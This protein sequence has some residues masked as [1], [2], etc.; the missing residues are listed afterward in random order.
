M[1]T[2]PT[3][4]KIDF[5]SPT[6]HHTLMVR[7]TQMKAAR[8][9]WLIA[10]TL[11]L[12]IDG[13]GM[14]RMVQDLSRET[15]HYPNTAASAIVHSFMAIGVS[16]AVG[17]IY[18]VT[19]I[20]LMLVSFLA[21][22]VILFR[23]K[24]NDWLALHTGFTL[25]VISAFYSQLSRYALEPI[26]P[27]LPDVMFILS[28][29]TLVLMMLLFPDGRFVPRWSPLLVVVMAF[30]VLIT[31]PTMLGWLPPAPGRNV[32]VHVIFLLLSLSVPA[33][34]YRRT[35]NTIERLQTQWLLFPGTGVLGVYIVLAFGWESGWFD[36]PLLTI[37]YQ[38]ISLL[39][40]VIVP[41]TIT[42]AVLRY[43]L[44]NIQLAVNRS[45]VYGTASIGLGVLFFIGAILLQSAL[46]RIEPTISAAITALGVGIF[47]NPTRHRVQNVID[48]RIYGFRFNL[49]E[50][51]KGQRRITAENAGV[52]TGQTLGHFMLM[53][54][55]GKGGMGEVY[56]AYGENGEMVAV[57]VLPDQLAKEDEFRTRFQLEAD[58]LVQLRH[59]N[60]V[61]LVASGADRGKF[62]IAMEFV[63]GRDLISLLRENGKIPL[64]D[65]KP[66]IRDFAEAIDYAHQR[67]FIH[68]DIKPANII[69]RMGPDN[70]NYEAVLMDFGI[71]KI[72]NAASHFTGSGAVG[73]I[74]YMA[75]EQIMTAREVDHRADIYALGVVLYEML[76]GQRPFTGSPGQVL[77]AHIQQPPPDPREINPDIPRHVAK[78][79]LKALEKDVDQRFQSAGE[80]AAAICA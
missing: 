30:Y 20:A 73:T 36:A 37:V 3:E 61:G 48:R 39:I 76:T 2:Q 5:D 15:M 70:E 59:R 23:N 65:V 47:F 19:I 38:T 79:I 69:L 56:R 42:V 45:I 10:A 68:R 54:V 24:P 7:P 75:P 77:F 13:M 6:T 66:F 35:F 63:E 22:A 27:A 60:I 8:R 31:R 62:Y 80:L 18:T 28:N 67:G 49:D 46:G 14:G 1:T 53:D 55:V 32:I 43:R 41:V 58:T 57:K 40:W 34:R 26:S 12:V 9:L 29:S 25:L 16:R 51:A 11:L 50:V 44:Y 52:M 4:R 72:K 78:A 17:I 33:Y 64:D 71:V 74:E 21:M